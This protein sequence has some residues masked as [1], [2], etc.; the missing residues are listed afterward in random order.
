MLQPASLLL[1]IFSKSQILAEKSTPEF[2][3]G[4][5]K[6][7]PVKILLVIYKIYCTT[8]F[9][10]IVFIKFSREEVLILPGNTP[11]PI[12]KGKHAL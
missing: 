8:L 7:G 12:Y 5:K 1:L 4:S 6:P 9:L 3:R 2:K 10:E 11:S